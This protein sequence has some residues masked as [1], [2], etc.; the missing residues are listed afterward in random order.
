MSE[1]TPV[2]LLVHVACPRVAYSDRGKASARVVAEP[3]L[4][5]IE[6]VGKRWTR[7]AKADERRRTATTRR[8]LMFRPQRVT[9]KDLCYDHM[10]EAW[11][12]ASGGLRTLWRQCF[13]VIRPVVDAKSDRPLLDKTFKNIFDDYLGDAQPMW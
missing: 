11:A 12:K 2:V 10:E 8:Q 5:A 3:V 7:Q 13:Y 9:L 6:S 4:T 1:R